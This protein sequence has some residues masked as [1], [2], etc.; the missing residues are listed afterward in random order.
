MLPAGHTFESQQRGAGDTVTE[1]LTFTN[2]SVPTWTI[3]AVDAGGK[4]LEV[5]VSSIITDPA[6]T[7]SADITANLAKLLYENTA[8]DVFQVNL[9]RR[10]EMDLA[11]GTSPAAV[12]AA[13]RD[14]NP[15]PFAAQWGRTL[16]LATRRINGARVYTRRDRARLALILRAKAIGSQLSEIKRYLDL[17]GDHG[18]GRSQQ[19]SYVIDR[20]D[21]A[22]TELEKKRAQI[23]ET[24]AELR[25]IN[26]SCKRHLDARRRTSNPST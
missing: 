25:V 14:A 22:I 16:R 9:S 18:E 2:T 19:L 7:S 4:R 3:G 8:G 1:T 24:L 10:W 12:Y 20:T 13:L 5:I 6:A 11:A 23:D 26:A 21:T 15:A 17:Y